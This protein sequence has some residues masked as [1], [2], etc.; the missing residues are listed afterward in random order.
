MIN[1]WVQ[2]RAELT[3]A[4]VSQSRTVRFDLVTRAI[5]QSLDSF[6]KRVVDIGGGCGRQAIQ[7]ARRGHDVLVVDSDEGMLNYARLNLLNEIPEV[8]RR[9]KLM[10]DRGEGIENKIGSDFDIVCCHSVLMYLS[11][12]ARLLESLAS[13]VKP[14]GIVSILTL[15]TRSLGMRE[16]L[17]GHWK[18]AKALVENPLF[19]ASRY[20]Q[21]ERH[22][23]NEIVAFFELKKLR[24]LA[25]YG[26]LVFT[27]HR[28]EE[29][30]EDEL[31][32]ICNLEWLAGTKDPYRQVARLKHL[33]LQEASPD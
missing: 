24:L 28:S 29:F 4:Y 19:T 23:E 32:D 12:P 33:I 9:I 25:W 7:L 17:L 21:S 8:R 20:L 3:S 31:V 13:L 14:N 5:L 2:N 16:G 6:P 26:V 1:R 27:D 22:D 11:E 30:S 18:D 10:H 15:N